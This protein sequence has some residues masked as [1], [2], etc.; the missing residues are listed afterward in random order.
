MFRICPHCGEEKDTR[1]FNIHII[2][3][4]ER[5]R[6]A[7]LQRRYASQLKNMTPEAGERFLK[8]AQGG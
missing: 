5:V 6:E 7:T 4:K 1:G 3:C 8:K 2:R